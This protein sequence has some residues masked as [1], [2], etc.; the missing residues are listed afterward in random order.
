M[1]YDRQEAI[2]N[3][4]KKYLN[5]MMLELAEL[6]YRGFETTLKYSVGNITIQIN[7]L[8]VN[9]DYSQTGVNLA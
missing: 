7:P 8:G 1:N 9:A 5:A 2:I 3:K 4:Y 6:E